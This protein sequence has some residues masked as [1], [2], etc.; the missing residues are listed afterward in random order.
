LESMDALEK[1]RREE[2]PWIVPFGPVE[3]CP[4]K[5]RDREQVASEAGR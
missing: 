5:G 4:L 2:H 1:P 3:R